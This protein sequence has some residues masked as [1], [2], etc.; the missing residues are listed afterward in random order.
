MGLLAEDFFAAASADFGDYAALHAFRIQG[1]QL[2]YA[3]EIFAGAVDRAFRSELYPLVEQLQ[4]KLGAINDHVTARAVYSD[5]L[6]RP[7]VGAEATA[8]PILIAEETTAVGAAR[9]AF[10]DWWSAERAGQ[11][12]AAFASCLA[13]KGLK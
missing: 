10:F 1:K 4:E 12:R 11:L 7:E 2:R 9:Q 5:W 8:L 6:A 13:V 3:M